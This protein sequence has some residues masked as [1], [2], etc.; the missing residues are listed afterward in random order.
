MPSIQNKGV[1]ELSSRRFDTMNRS[2]F[3]DLKKNADGK[4]FVKMSERSNMKRSTILFDLDDDAKKLVEIL[5][6]DTVEKAAIGESLGRFQSSMFSGTEIEIEKAQGMSVKGNVKLR[7]IKDDSGRGPAVFFEI[8]KLSQLIEC[9]REFCEGGFTI[10]NQNQSYQ[11]PVPRTVNDEDV[12]SRH[13]GMLNRM[14]YLDLKKDSNDGSYYIKMSERSNRK[15]STLLFN[16]GEDAPRLLEILSVD[17]AEAATD[18]EILGTFP[19]SKMADKQF[20][21]QKLLDNNSSGKIRMRQVKSGQLHGPAVFFDID[22]LPSLIEC[23]KD[24]SAVCGE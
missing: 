9:I 21:V 22:L 16:I 2:V 13:F 17:K 10:T 5:A 14:V 12:E 18:G 20:E 11:S 23:I 1:Q 3:L 19:C 4:L 8:D 6:V 15:R 7:Q 24:F